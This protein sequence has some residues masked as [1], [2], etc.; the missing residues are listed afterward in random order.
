MIFVLTLL[1]IM[2]YPKIFEVFELLKNKKHSLFH[3]TTDTPQMNF[4]QC[5]PVKSPNAILK[6]KKKNENRTSLYSVKNVPN[7]KYLDNNTPSL[8]DP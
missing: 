8:N 6:D 5:Y 2:F 4:S 1:M 7:E 3:P